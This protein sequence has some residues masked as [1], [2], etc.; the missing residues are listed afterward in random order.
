[1]ERRIGILAQ[2]GMQ[3]FQG[4]DGFPYPEGRRSGYGV[5]HRLLQ[6]TPVMMISDGACVGVADRLYIGMSVG[7][8]VGVYVGSSEG[9]TAGTAVGFLV[10]V[11]VGAR[12]GGKVGLSVGLLVGAT[13]GR[14]V[15]EWVGTS[16]G[17]G[18]EGVHLGVAVAFIGGSRDGLDMRKHARSPHDCVGADPCRPRLA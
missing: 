13:V 15:G 10:G 9:S 6:R 12:N 11:G 8:R 1:M 14:S 5:I 18:V 17:V 2:K 3:P 4:P 7:A 16:V